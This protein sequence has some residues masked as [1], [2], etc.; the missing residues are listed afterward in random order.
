MQLYIEDAV[1]KYCTW[2][3]V[4]RL[5]WS[6]GVI[7]ACV[8]CYMHISIANTRNWGL[9]SSFRL[10]GVSLAKAARRSRLAD[11]TSSVCVCWNAQLTEKL[12]A[13]YKP[14]KEQSQGQ[15]QHTPSSS[16][17][18]TCQHMISESRTQQS[19]TTFARMAM[20]WKAVRIYTE[21]HG[22]YN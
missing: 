1:C 2:M 16:Q 19:R 11:I 13:T 20:R 5:A 8:V 18:V 12:V 3:L 10:T 15:S 9:H 21:I 7:K 17:A 4:R 6:A 14:Y 22:F